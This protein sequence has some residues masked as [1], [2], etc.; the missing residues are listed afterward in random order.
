MKKINIFLAIVVALFASFNLQAQGRYGAD[1]AECVKYLSIYLDYMKINNLDEAA[2]MWRKAIKYCPPT[3]SQNMLLDGMKILRKE[4]YT[5]RN[6]PIRKKELLDSLFMLHDLRCE[7]F[8]KY[9]VTARS[10]K[11]LDFIKYMADENPAQGFKFM[12]EAM[13]AA[14]DKTPI[15]VV[16]RYMHF[17]SV[18]YSNGEMTAEQVIDAFGK[19]MQVAE[20]V[21]AKKP[22]SN[23]DNAIADIE[24]LF[25]QS[26]VA[27]CE[28]LVALFQPR[29]DA[30]PANKEVLAAIVNL[31]SA[32]NCTSEELFLKA[33][34]GLYA[35]EPSHNSAYLLYKLYNSNNNME[36]AEKYMMEAIA[37][38][39]SDAEQ[40]ATYYL[41]LATTLFK[42]TS[43]NS[44]KAVGLAKQAAS[45]SKNVEG[46]AY[47]LIGNIWASIDI[48]GNDIEKRSKYWVA[49]DY[50]NKAQKADPTLAE[51]AKGLIANCVKYYPLQSEA[52]MYDIID[53]A[54]YTVKAQG[55]SETT[56][57]RTQK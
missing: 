39:E 46:K 35:Q 16:V 6:N 37:F 2:P 9:K 51:T 30:D 17:A 10:N 20:S 57:V 3:A 12:E 11:A 28:S 47:L 34:E 33:V 13:D 8:P 32:S 50:L 49:V 15:S 52:F 42:K 26:G 21:R 24:N 44:A 31:M 56:V 36:M 43:S 5:Y 41:E 4:I 14:K 18:L 55:M 22:S 25:M 48:Q 1:S 40:D 19:A 7:N 29:Y 54:Q 27:T 53:G 38:E 45:L 23:I